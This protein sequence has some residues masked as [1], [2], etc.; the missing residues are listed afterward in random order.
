MTSFQSSR[1]FTVILLVA[2]LLGFAKT[3]DADVVLGNYPDSGEKILFTFY[4]D[5][6]GATHYSNG[7]IKKQ[8]HFEVF[9][10]DTHLIP[11]M[12]NDTPVESQKSPITGGAFTGTSDFRI[13]FPLD[14]SKYNV[15][16]IAF[17]AI[18]NVGFGRIY[19]GEEK[20]FYRTS[21][22]LLANAFYFKTTDNTELSNL[23]LEK[24]IVLDFIIPNFNPDSNAPNFKIEIYGTE[25]RQN[26]TPE[27]ATLFIFA[28]GMVGAGV[29]AYRRRRS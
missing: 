8:Q 26:N 13:S 19:I 25:I 29:A 14:F 20:V 11:L 15:E 23:E 18:Q 16:A 6:V 27:P 28:S 5:F 24:N 3:S 22:L 17:T 1:L 21:P 7:R 2:F 9:E 12:V 4:V 10:D